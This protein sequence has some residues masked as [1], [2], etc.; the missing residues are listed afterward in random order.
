MFFSKTNNMLPLK[1]ASNGK[2]DIVRSIAAFPI[3]TH[4]LD[5]H[6]ANA[7]SWTKHIMSQRMR[8]KI[9][10]HHTPKSQVI[11]LVFRASDFIDND[12]FFCLEITLNQAWI[13]H[14]AKQLDGTLKIFAQNTSIIDGGLVWGKGIDFSAYL[15]KFKSYLLPVKRFCALKNH[16]LQKVGNARDTE[17]G[18]ITRTRTHVIWNSNRFKIGHRLTYY[19]QPIG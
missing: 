15:I 6:I 11:G 12:F 18:F 13:H 1:V 7:F 10:L 17:I 4:L 16:M 3:V 14:I 5:A 9:R 19:L 8:T 2:N